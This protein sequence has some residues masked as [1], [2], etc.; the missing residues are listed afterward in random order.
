[1]TEQAYEIT[2]LQ[3][4]IDILETENNDF[5]MKLSSLAETIKTVAEKV[6]TNVIDSVMNKI[7]EQQKL[8]ESKTTSL[9]DGIQIQMNN[10][11]TLLCPKTIHTSISPRVNVEDCSTP[12][13]P[14]TSQHCTICDRSFASKKVY[15]DHHAAQHQQ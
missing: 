7:N 13:N 6:V 3:D 12:K 9:L 11:T 5:K 10:L 8:N 14:T 15:N 2:K 4:R 1:M